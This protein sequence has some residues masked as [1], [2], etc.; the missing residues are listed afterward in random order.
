MRREPGQGTFLA[1]PRLRSNLAYLCS[2]SEEIEHWGHEPGA[3]LVSQK[4]TGADKT[5]AKRLV[6][7]PGEVVLYVRWLR[8]ADGQPIFVCDSYLP[9]IRFPKL[10]DADYSSVSLREL[11]ENMTGRKFARLAVNRGGGSR[12]CCRPARYRS[13]CAGAQDRTRNFRGRGGACRE[14]R[15]ILP[16]RTLPTLRRALLATTLL[17]TSWY[18]RVNG[19]RCAAEADHYWVAGPVSVVSWEPL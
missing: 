7:E 2:F 12:R 11:F 10:R 13:W 15:G 3:R 6:M 19:V 1:S 5:I 8:L 14:R 4:E 18:G 17:A 9:I 16:P